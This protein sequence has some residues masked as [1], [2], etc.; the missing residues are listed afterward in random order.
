MRNPRDAGCVA[1]V[2][3]HPST[4]EARLDRLCDGFVVRAF[5]TAEE[6][7]DVGCVHDCSC[8]TADI[9]MPGMPGLDLQARLNDDRL[10]MPSSSRLTAISESG[11]APCERAQLTSW[12]SLYCEVLLDTLRAARQ[13]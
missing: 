12:R 6:F 1:I 3:D 9:R 7:L 8:P 4:P 13:R 11:S 2:D 10:R 5:L